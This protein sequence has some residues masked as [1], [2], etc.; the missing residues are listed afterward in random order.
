MSS[1]QSPS[2][3]RRVKGA[4][5]PSTDRAP[6]KALSAVLA[7][8]LTSAGGSAQLKVTQ[9]SESQDAGQKERDV[10]GA[11][12]DPRDAADPRRE[13]ETRAPE[14]SLGGGDPAL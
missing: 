4:K 5:E 3:D 2:S 13:C 9:V 7:V 1:M 11:D 8:G 6:W 10:D 14:E 12:Q